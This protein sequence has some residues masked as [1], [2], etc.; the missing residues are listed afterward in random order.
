MNCCFV[1]LNYRI[2][3]RVLTFFTPIIL[4]GITFIYKSISFHSISLAL[5]ESDRLKIL[6]QTIEVIM[7]AY[8]SFLIA[9]ASN[10]RL[11]QC[12]EL[13]VCINQLS[14]KYVHRQVELGARRI[15][16]ILLQHQM[17]ESP[18]KNRHAKETNVDETNGHQPGCRIRSD[19]I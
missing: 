5:L 15:G 1:F 6:Y 18:K 3:C 2:E 7:R 12:C 14:S 11:A 4:N 19:R 9:R 17:R 13:H 8:L 10:V 16:E